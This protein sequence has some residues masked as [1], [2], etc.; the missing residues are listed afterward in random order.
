MRCL[1]DLLHLLDELIDAEARWPLT[2]RILL[3]RL[4]ELAHHDGAAIN[5]PA[6]SD[7]N[8]S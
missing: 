1:K 4:K 8:Q 6:P 5:T 3:E 2:W 7:M